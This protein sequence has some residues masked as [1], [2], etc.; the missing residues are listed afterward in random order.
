M[1]MRVI[2]CVLIVLLF[3]ARIAAEEPADNQPKMPPI[4]KL[5]DEKVFKE[6]FAL[7]MRQ[8]EARKDDGSIT[9]KEKANSLEHAFKLLAQS[10]DKAGNLTLCV[11]YEGW[12]LFSSGIE[13]DEQVSQDKLITLFIFGVAIKK[14]EDKARPFSFW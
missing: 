3:N 2:A 1:M 7:I 11:E 6:H 14:G 12:Y 9:L 13:K 10:S 5:K 8:T 4:L